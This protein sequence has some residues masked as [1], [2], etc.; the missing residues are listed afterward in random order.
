MSL[1]VS[2]PQE[3]VRGVPCGPSHTAEARFPGEVPVKG[4][5]GLR[6]GGDRRTPAGIAVPAQN[7]R[8]EPRRLV[9]CG[10]GASWASA[11]Q[12]MK[13]SSGSTRAPL[14]RE[15]VGGEARVF[16]QLEVLPKQSVVVKGIA[17]RRDEG[18]ACRCSSTQI[19]VM[20]LLPS[21]WWAAVA[22]PR[23]RP[24]GKPVIAVLLARN[25]PVWST[26]LT[27]VQ[28][29]G[30]SYIHQPDIV[31]DIS[32]RPGS[33][34][35]GC[36][37]A[38]RHIAVQVGVGG[39][40]PATCTEVDACSMAWRDRGSR[41][42]WRPAQYG[43]ARA[44]CRG[45]RLGRPV[46]GGLHHPYLLE[47]GAPTYDPWIGLTAIVP[48][49]ERIRIGTTV[50]PLPRRRPWQLAREAV[51]LDHLSGGP[52]TLGVDIGGL[53][54]VANVEHFGEA[55]GARQR[56]AMLD[57][58]LEILAGLWS[59]ARFSHQGEH[60]RVA[61][62][63]FLPPPV[64]QPRIPIWVGG[65]AHTCGVIRR[66]A[67]WD[68][69]VPVPIPLD[70]GGWRYLAPDEVRTLRA[71]AA[72]ERSTDAQFDMALSGQPRGPD[73]AA[74]QDRIAALTAAGATW[75]LEWVP[76]ADRATMHAAIARGPLR[77]G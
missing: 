17:A 62:T 75:W 42:L 51:T 12:E 19:S 10:A 27:C 39:S 38:G 46:L 64:Q 49:T 70:H 21:T 59:S 65:S 37:G 16:E 33:C 73:P 7:E 15:A 18:G 69:I 61:E 40:L 28:G 43:G 72:R 9:A 68:G 48:V 36:A 71:T 53:Q 5:A 35:A 29:P 32:D 45:V 13:P 3:L 50:T 1:V 66:A 20:R 63:T 44:D 6:R 24:S 56:A 23:R 2:L 34:R 58:G 54:D 77:S 76:A 14:D 74:E 26:L 25:P 67:R 57:E 55:S 22:V 52:L 47:G 4:A 30:S 8:Y 41:R 11:A 60:Y 31:V